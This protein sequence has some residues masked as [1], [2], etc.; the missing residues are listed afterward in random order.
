MQAGHGANNE[1]GA[2]ARLQYDLFGPMS[3]FIMNE[4]NRGA[5]LYWN[6]AALTPTAGFGLPRMG[7]AAKAAA[8]DDAAVRIR[9]SGETA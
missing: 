4:I 9:L 6:G 1:I 3:E 2:Q 5:P 8:T 7:I